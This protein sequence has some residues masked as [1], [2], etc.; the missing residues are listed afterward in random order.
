MR[1]S[2]G[3][4]LIIFDCDGVLVDSEVISIAIDQDLLAE[5]G[6]K[7]S[8]NE[9]VSHFVGRS[10]AHFIKVVEEHIGRKL[11]DD[12][13]VAYQRIY[14]EA[15]T[16]NLQPIAGITEALD[17]IS[18]PT[19]VASNGSHEKMR[20]TLGL[21]GLLPRFEGR[22]FSASDVL[23]GKPAPDLFLH[24]SKTLGFPAKHCLVVED[25]V[26]GVEAALAAEMKVIAYAGG[27]TPRH[28]L[29]REDVIIIDQMSE[30]PM[31]IHSATLK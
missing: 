21:T 26:A 9:I 27:V 17:L 4:S 23:H 20:F 13:E 14:R 29:M 5:L 16:R 10:H 1:N 8:Q 19:C 2:A 15:L 31:A 22:I 24:A 7:V 6:W 28:Q 25:S 18:N 12:W 30:L 11:P 3:R